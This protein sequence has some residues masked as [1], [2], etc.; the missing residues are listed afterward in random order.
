MELGVRPASPSVV[1]GA[2]DDIAA[3][4]SA[5]AVGGAAAS[6]PPTGTWGPDGAA[7][8]V[9]VRTWGARRRRLNSDR[10]NLGARRRCLGGGWRRQVVGIEASRRLLLGA[11]FTNGNNFGCRG[12]RSPDKQKMG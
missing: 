11:G 9:E 3:A 8:T 5:I 6:G 1:G 7:S 4:G 2:F 10:R 12:G